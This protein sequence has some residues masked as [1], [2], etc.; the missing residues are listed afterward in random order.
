MSQRE[1]GTNEIRRISSGRRVGSRSALA[2]KFQRRALF[3]G[4]VRNPGSGGE[5]A[6]LHRVRLALPV[7][8]CDG[9]RS[10]GWRAPPLVEVR[11]LI[12]LQWQTSGCGRGAQ[13][14]KSHGPLS[15]NR[16][17]LPHYA[18]NPSSLTDAPLLF[19]LGKVFLTC[20]DITSEWCTGESEFSTCCTPRSPVPMQRC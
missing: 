2:V 8:K 16:L 5:A 3:S 18:A 15:D 4:T 6:E 20:C 14:L 7:V 12:G 13:G 9:P 10:G 1:G 11:A 19:F 17:P